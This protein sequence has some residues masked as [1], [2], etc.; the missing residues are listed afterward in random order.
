MQ[1]VQL[2]VQD[3]CSPIASLFLEA[4]GMIGEPHNLQWV[5]WDLLPTVFHW[6]L[7]P[8]SQMGRLTLL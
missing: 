3:A 2:P 8:I 6:C 5:A 7:S 1:V 4:S